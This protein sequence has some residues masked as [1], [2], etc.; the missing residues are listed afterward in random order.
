V[1][2]VAV[3][4]VSTYRDA[5]TVRGVRYYYVIEAINAIGSSPRSSESTAIAK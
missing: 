2:L 3:G 1:F 4:A 5:A